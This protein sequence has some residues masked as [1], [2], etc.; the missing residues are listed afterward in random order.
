MADAPSRSRRKVAVLPSTASPRTVRYFDAHVHLHPPRLAAAIERV[1]RPRE[2]AHRPLPSSRRRSSRRCAPAAS[3]ASASSPT[4]TSP[5]WPARSTSGWRRPPSRYP[6]AIALGTLHADDP[7]LE[8]TAR[9]ALDGLGLRG[10]K[11]HRSVQRFSRRRPSALPRVRA[12]RGGGPS[13]SCSTWGPCPTAI[14]SPAS[15]AS[16]G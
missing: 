5:A 6:Q 3:S 10:F 7:D 8:A 1:V 9:D 4:R 11:F 12:R 2:L 15:S 13:A 14:P 16:P